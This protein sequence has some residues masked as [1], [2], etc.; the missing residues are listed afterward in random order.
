G[1]GKKERRVA[2]EESPHRAG[3]GGGRGSPRLDA[4]RFFFPPTAFTK[5]AARPGGRGVP[6]PPIT[7]ICDRKPEALRLAS[8]WEVHQMDTDKLAGSRRTCN[9]S[10]HCDV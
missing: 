4:E 5:R 8:G 9:A 3:G 1:D 7:R 6:N 2:W 10:R